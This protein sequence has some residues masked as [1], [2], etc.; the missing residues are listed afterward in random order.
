MFSLHLPALIRS[1]TMSRNKRRG[2]PPLR[3]SFRPRLE[4]LEH[5][6]MLA[7]DTWTG[8][9]ASQGG[10]LNW[11]NAGNWSLN[12]AP[13]STDTALFTSG[14]TVKTKTA[15]VDTAFTI[16]NLT[17]DSTWGGSIHVQNT[18]NVTGNFKLQSG[19]FGGAGPVTIGGTDSRLENTDLNMGAGGFVNNG[20]LAIKAITRSVFF[21]GPGTYTNNGTIN[22]SGAN[23][24]EL[25]LNNPVLNNTG[26][27]NLTSDNNIFLLS[28][29]INNTGKVKKSTTS[30]TSTIDGFFNNQG[31]TI[32]VQTGQLNLSGNNNLFSGGVFSV[33]QGATL[34]LVANNKFTRFAGT[35][36]G[37]GAGTVVLSHGFLT[38]QP[39]GVTFNLPG[40]LFHWSG[41]TIDVHNGGAFTN[42]ASGTINVDPEVGFGRFLEG[43][44]DLINLGKINQIG[45]SNLDL[46]SAVL[47]NAAGATYNLDNGNISGGSSSTIVNAGL[48]TKGVAASGISFISSGLSNTGRVEVHNGILDLEG[49]ISQ[50]FGTELAGGTWSVFGSATVHASLTFL[51]VGD[52]TALGPGTSVTLNGPNTDFSNLH[53]L[54]TIQAGASFSLLGGQSLTLPGR[55][56][57]SGTLTLSPGSLLTVQSTFIQNSTATLV[58]QIGGTNAAPLVGSVR[59]NAGGVTL[60]G[61]LT[62]S[63]TVQPAINTA[64][65]ILDN[66]AA[67]A[68]TGLFSALPEGATFTVKAGGVNMTF[69]ISYVGGNGH[70]V[71]IKRTA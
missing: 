48:F 47:H 64:F 54:N 18:L 2:K 63:S 9:S 17:A 46:G 23:Q 7:T 16:L 53:K 41:G 71:S 40:N 69:K 36:T 51:S 30:G 15:T 10:S 14:S 50:V 56:T 5:R 25:G 4:A 44:G 13:G 68:I 45:S 70:S 8:L 65:T 6:T 21:N 57:N 24:F 38:V 66:E 62:V 37:S 31:G 59:S 34:D 3:P 33:S 43:P 27:L 67:S 55:L 60:A 1:T 32:N 49:P 22:L 11:S 35:F 58:I 20:S 39:E 52:L 26:T 12:A 19:F 61:K 42:A 28:G 29:T